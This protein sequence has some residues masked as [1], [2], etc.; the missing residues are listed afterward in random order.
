MRVGADAHAGLE[1]GTITRTVRLWRKPLVK[2]GGH[3]RT[4][5]VTVEVDRMETV[6]LAS[7]TDDDA[8]AS[9]FADRVALLAMLT[10][11]AGGE[12]DPSTPVWRIDFHR[13]ADGD[14]RPGLRARLAHQGDITKEEAFD[15]V[16]RLDGLDRRA[17]QGQ[18]TRGVLRLIAERPG[19]V[20]TEL[21]AS[22]GRDRASFKEDVRKLK[23]LGLTE[24]LERGYRLSPRGRSLLDRLG[25]GT[26]GGANGYGAHRD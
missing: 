8:R 22:I 6:A 13:V 25:I 24:S 1:A 4:G 23:R 18:W 7:I 14:D 21:A 15:I 11:I 5:P 19:V 17:P 3:Y 20:S 10:R 2:V 9:G 16:R 12:P 26:T